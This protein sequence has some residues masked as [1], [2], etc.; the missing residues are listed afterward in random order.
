MLGERMADVNESEYRLL[1]AMSETTQY[2]LAELVES[3]GVES[4]G[5]ERERVGRLL[6]ELTR[7]GYVTKYEEGP[8]TEY[9]LSP[10]GVGKRTMMRS[11]AKDGP[12]G[13]GDF[14]K[15]AS[16][17]HHHAGIAAHRERMASVPLS[18][19]ERA[20]CAASLT[21]QHQQIRFDWTDLTRR[22]S[23]LTA[24]VTHGQLLDV[25]DGLQL[26]PLY[27]EHSPPPD[28]L[29]KIGSGVRTGFLALRLLFCLPF[30]LSGIAILKGASN[31]EEYL[32]A[33]M[34]IG[35]SIFFAYPALRHI[36]SSLRG[37]SR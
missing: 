10:T 12:V 29:E 21:A 1:N 34:F 22:R 27:G 16:T 4:S 13:W 20:L 28:R 3:S 19:Q 15:A 35:G 9:R 26:P 7:E 6:A 25:F 14:L 11:L 33:A 17:A 8:R 18:E 37:G 36:A 24:A 23:L 2:S 32:G 30:F 5:V 31:P